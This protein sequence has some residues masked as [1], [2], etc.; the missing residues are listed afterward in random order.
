[1]TAMSPIVILFVILLFIRIT[2]FLTSGYNH[3]KD[4]LVPHLCSFVGK[5]GR[6]VIALPDGLTVG[7]CESIERPTFEVKQSQCISSGCSP[8]FS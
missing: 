3:H 2:I 1:M 5:G 7:P 8:E 6:A 4:R